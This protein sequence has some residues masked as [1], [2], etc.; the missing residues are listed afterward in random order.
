MF[1]KCFSNDFQNDFCATFS[2]DRGWLCA[3]QA[4]LGKESLIEDGGMLTHML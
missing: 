4:L 3:V 2:F 1:H